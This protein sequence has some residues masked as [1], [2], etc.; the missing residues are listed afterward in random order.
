MKHTKGEWKIEIE[1]DGNLWISSDKKE[2]LI[3]NICCSQ[4]DTNKYYPTNEEKANAKL[5][6]TA[7]ELLKTLQ[8]IRDSLGVPIA[9]STVKGLFKL[10]KKATE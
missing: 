2:E 4:D 9:Q 8:F 3:A 5:I 6:A 1:S 10:A 7:P